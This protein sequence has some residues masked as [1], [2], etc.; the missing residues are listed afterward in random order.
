M[1]ESPAPS[2]QLGH[3]IGFRRRWPVGVLVG[4]TTLAVLVPIAL[5]LPNVY[6]SKASLLVDQ[7]TS[8]IGQSGTFSQ[9]D[10]RLQAIK[11]EALSRQRITE[12]I[13]RLNLY[14]EMRRRGYDAIGRVQKDVK[15][16]ILSATRADGRTVAFTVSYLGNDPQKVADVANRLA[17]FYVEKNGDLRSRQAKQNAEILRNEID[18]SKRRLEAHE[19]RLMEFTSRNSS[20]LPQQVQATLARYTQLTASL[21]MNTS[22]QTSLMTQKDSLESQI[23]ALL[24]PRTTTDVTD[25]ALKL[26]LAEKELTALEVKGYL[27]NHPQVKGK[28]EE[29]A[30]LRAQ[31]AAKQTD[32]NGSTGTSQVS[33]LQGHVANINDR[34][35]AIKKSIEDTNDE[36]RA[37]N[38][39]LRKAPLQDA[40]FEKLN[41]EV[42]S[43]RESYDTLQKSSQQALLTERAEQGKTGEEF[44]ILDPALP[45]TSSTAPNRQLL[46]GGSVLLAFALGLGVIFLLEQMDGSF[47]SVDELRA[48]TNVPVLATIPR[49]QTRRDRLRHLLVSSAVG[50]GA[51]GAL[52]FISQKVFHIAQNA[53]GITR[54][55]IRLG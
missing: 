29:I 11:Q 23:A 28:K 2:S 10:G 51:L 1:L 47:R 50:V 52:W 26:A 22:T 3:L 17:Q 31:V 46:L 36:M 12:L 14:P 34:L 21:Q 42:K 18:A 27:D 20:S 13:E 6:T 37:A 55:L 35:A 16:D 54:M 41:R 9:L 30:A 40:E 8:T 25:P 7:L 39:L 38:A 33:T 53:E 4:A 15:V 45:A 32:G 24:T 49:I 48:F 5:G 44:Q 43:A 19:T